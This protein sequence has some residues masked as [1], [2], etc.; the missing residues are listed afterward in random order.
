M[1]LENQIL[2]RRNFDL[3]HRLL[4]EAAL[5]HVMNEWGCLDFTRIVFKCPN[6]AHAADYIMRAFP[7]SAMI[8]LIRDGRDVLRSRFSAFGSEE[9]AETA[10]KG[11]RLHAIAYYS[12]WWNF[13]VDIIASA[14]DAHAPERRVFVRYEDLRRHTEDTAEKIFR[15]VGLQI[16]PE[17]LK[18]LVRDTRLESLHDRGSDK[19]RQDG[20]VGG[21][22]AFFS[23]EEIALM[24]TIMGPNL[25]K[26]GYSAG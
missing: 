14:Y 22:K 10:H 20:R 7:E 17:D 13:Q 12:H 6:E 5:A 4:R 16:A 11:L 15:G 25:R 2:S 1:R 24:D 9:L 8:F 18:R 26:Y 21:F 3:Y 23:D 19:P